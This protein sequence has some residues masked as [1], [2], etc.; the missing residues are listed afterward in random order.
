MKIIIFIIQI[1]IFLVAIIWVITKI[2]LFIAPN[3]IL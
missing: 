2:I 1:K 3:I